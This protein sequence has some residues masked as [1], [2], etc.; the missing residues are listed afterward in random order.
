MLPLFRGEFWDSYGGINE[1]PT[2][3]ISINLGYMWPFVALLG[4]L[5]GGFKRGD[6]VAPNRADHLL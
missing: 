6:S 5:W 2:T 3:I 1:T 4:F